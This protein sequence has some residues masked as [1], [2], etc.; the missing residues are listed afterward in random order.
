MRVKSSALLNYQLSDEQLVIMGKS[1]K[2]IRICTKKE[3]SLLKFPLFILTKNHRKFHKVLDDFKSLV[4]Q[5][6]SEDH[7]C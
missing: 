7:G 6:I 1:F 5:I 3:L 2:F 4:A